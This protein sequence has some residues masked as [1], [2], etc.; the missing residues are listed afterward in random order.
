MDSDCIE[1][2]LLSPNIQ[3]SQICRTSSQIFFK[4]LQTTLY[5]TCEKLYG[6]RAPEPQEENIPKAF[7]LIC[8]IL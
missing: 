1:L 5:T 7:F 3:A 2:V 4:A 6:S 8:E